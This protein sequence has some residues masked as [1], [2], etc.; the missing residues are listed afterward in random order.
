MNKTEIKKLIRPHK[1]KLTTAKEWDVYAKEH[2]LPSS[3]N[4]IY[5]FGS[6][7][8]T[9]KT[10][11]LSGQKASYT[12]AELKQI[13]TEHKEYMRSK[14]TWD[15]YSKEKGLPASATFIKAFGKWS[16]LKQFI[17]L[18]GEKRKSDI[19]SKE[20]I[21]SILNEHAAE[22][23]SRQQWDVYAKENKLPTYKT[24]KK[25]FTYDEILEIV[26]KKKTFNFTKSDLIKIALEH[27]DIFLKASMTVWDE[28]ASEQ[29]LPSSHTFFSSFGSW[30]IAKH[31]VH[32]KM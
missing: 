9:K 21:K 28:Y 19:Y 22:Y 29:R 3:F 4:L 7:N 8:E 6:W 26:G 16:E 25:H 31:E 14:P 27:K 32:L 1:N 10:F 17:G 2:E 12:F 18:S 23:Q 15:Q 20:H 11:N 24:I 30:R 5:I 13:A